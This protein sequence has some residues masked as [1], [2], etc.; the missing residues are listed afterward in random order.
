MIDASSRCRSF[1]EAL[2][3]KG[4]LEGQ[5]LRCQLEAPVGAYT[6]QRYVR[7]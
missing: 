3:E 1:W 2:A 6:S 7:S 4:G 5:A